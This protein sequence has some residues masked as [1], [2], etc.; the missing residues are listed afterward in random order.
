MAP[1]FAAEEALAWAMKA[2]EAVEEAGRNFGPL[3]EESRL[4]RAAY[5]HFM[6][7]YHDLA[8]AKEESG[9]WVKVCAERPGCK[10]CKD[11]DV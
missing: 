8:E 9:H 4:A 2:A 10:G 1:S 7:D 5:E 3:S 11:Y 6:D